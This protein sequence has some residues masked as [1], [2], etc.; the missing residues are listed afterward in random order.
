MASD[1]KPKFTRD[2]LPDGTT[3]R[4]ATRSSTGGGNCVE[5]A[6]VLHDDGTFFLMRDSKDPS[7]P[8]LTF[9][10]AEWHAFTD[11]VQ[12]DEFNL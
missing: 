11:G 6:K 7:G 9:D 5:V 8:V 2:D 1:N 12:D 10:P 3:W 4:K